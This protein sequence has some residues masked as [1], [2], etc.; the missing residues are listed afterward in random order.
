L[1]AL[2][3]AAKNNK[4]DAVRMLVKSGVELNCQD[5]DGCTALH[6]AA[7]LGHKDIVSLLLNLQKIDVSLKNKLG[8]TAKEMATSSDIQKL[9]AN[10]ENNQL[11]FFASLRSNRQIEKLLM[12]VN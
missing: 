6:Y 2:H 3:I 11:G 10:N 4:I 12:K 9:F 7:E 1:S 5:E 8:W